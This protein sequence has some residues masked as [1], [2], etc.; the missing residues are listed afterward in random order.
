MSVFLWTFESITVLLCFFLYPNVEGVRQSMY[1]IFMTTEVVCLL[2]RDEVVI[3]IVK[4]F[5]GKHMN[6]K[7]IYGITENKYQENKEYFNV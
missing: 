1:N 4:I 7:K 3:F 5:G 6:I 2:G